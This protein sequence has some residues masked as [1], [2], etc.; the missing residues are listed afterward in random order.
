MSNPTLTSFLSA[1]FPDENEEIHFRAFKPK[2]TAAQT[3]NGPVLITGTRRQLAENQ[4]FR[5]RLKKLNESRGLYFA[6]NA[7]GSKDERIVR[8]NAAFCEK[9][10]L[11]IAEKHRLFDSAPLSPSIRV[12]SKR[13][14]H[15]YWLL[16]GNCSADQWASLQLTLIDYFHS[17]PKIRNPS[18]V[19]RI[20]YFDHL[21]ED[22]SGCVVRQRVL[23]VHFHP[24]QRYSIDQILQAFSPSCEPS[25][26]SGLTT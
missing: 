20:P 2:G 24:E 23:L 3:D 26:Q 9:D 1:F 19:M 17:D 10:D 5:Q 7:G 6:P 22:T 21:F 4:S 16:K 14:V 8:F 11:P 12:E 13:S 18:R 15:A 25:D